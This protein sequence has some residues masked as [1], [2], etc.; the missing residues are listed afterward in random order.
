MLFCDTTTTTTTSSSSSSDVTRAV[1]KA[2]AKRYGGSSSS[3]NGQCTYEIFYAEE[4][5]SK[6]RLV[7]DVFTFPDNVTKV[8]V[9]VGCESGETGEIYRQKADGILGM[10]NN[11]G[12]FHGEVRQGGGDARGGVGGMGEKGRPLGGV[13]HTRQGVTGS[14]RLFEWSEECK[15]RQRKVRF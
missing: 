4:S 11:K 2:L 13:E 9:T 15:T 1:Q 5:T 14:R 7:R 8:P 10:G 3:S 6:G 12:T